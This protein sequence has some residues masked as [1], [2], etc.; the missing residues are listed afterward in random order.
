MKSGHSLT[1]L[2]FVETNEE[3]P[4]YAQ[5]FSK[6]CL[7]RYSFD[8]RLGWRKPC[9][10][11]HARSR[12]Q[13]GSPSVTRANYQMSDERE[14]F[15]GSPVTI[16]TVNLTRGQA[17]TYNHPKTS[18]INKIQTAEWFWIVRCEFWYV[19]GCAYVLSVSYG[20][21][22]MKSNAEVRLGSG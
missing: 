21:C 20:G 11:S 10:T 16:R 1:Q 14:W 3:L 19:R 15:K 7:T 5:V 4:A 2:Q 18:D 9:D 8:P 6:S 22:T 12:R 13:I 17:Q